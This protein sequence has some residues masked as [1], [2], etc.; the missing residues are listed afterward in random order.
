[1]SETNAQPDR[2]GSLSKENAPWVVVR[3]DKAVLCSGCGVQVK[4]PAEVVGRRVL[5]VD[6]S[7]Q[8]K[9]VDVTIPQ[10]DDLPVEP[11][12]PDLPA[13]DV[14]PRKANVRKATAKPRRIDG[15][16]LPSAAEM[17]R[18]FAWVSFHL[19]LLGLQGSEFK[20]LQ[21]LFR[22]HRRREQLAPSSPCPCQERPGSTIKNAP[23]YQ[24]PHARP[25]G[26]ANKV[27]AI[28]VVG[29]P[30]HEVRSY[31]HADVGMAPELNNANERGPP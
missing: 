11:S 1:M 24:A 6:Q 10:A 26:H 19:K 23:T 13:A 5:V 8:D 31:A 14:S 21:K 20:R 28:K 12:T 16:R 29:Q 2:H 27:P 9:P 25:R 4:V 15:L 3:A 17:E 18:G 22:R 7:P 30:N